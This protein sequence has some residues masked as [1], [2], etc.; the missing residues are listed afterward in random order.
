MNFRL[1]SRFCGQV[2][3]LIA[4]ILLVQALWCFY[5][6]ASPDLGLKLIAS[7]VVILASGIILWIVGHKHQG[8]IKPREA[9][10]IVA[11]AWFLMSIVG[12]LPYLLAETSLHFADAFFE[13]VSGFTT[14]GST[15]LKDIEA[16][17]DAVL[18]WRSF[19]QWI[20]GLGVIVLFVSI[21]PSLGVAGGK[22]LFKMEMPGPIKENITPKIR[23]TTRYLLYAYLMLTVVEAL[24]LVFVS[25]MPWFD[26]ITHS[27]STISTGGFS[28][29]NASI[30]SYHSAS[31]EWII[32]VFMFL[33]GTNFGLYYL[34]IHGQIKVALKDSE[35]RFYAVLIVLLSSIITISLTFYNGH[36]IDDSVRRNLSHQI[37]DQHLE[38]LSLLKQEQ[39]TTTF[40]LMQELERV[41]ITEPQVQKMIIVNSQKNYEWQIAIRKS[42]FQVVALI[43]TTGF[44]SDD[45]ELYPVFVHMFLFYLLFCGGCAGSTA[46]GVKLFRILLIGKTFL[47]EIKTGFRPALVSKIRVGSTIISNDLIRTVLAFVGIY[48]ACIA[49]GALYLGLEGHSLIT[50]LT[51][52]MTAVG[53]F[54]PGFGEIG[55]TE[56][57]SHFSSDAKIMLGIL[58]LLGRLE[59]FTLLTFLHYRFWK[60]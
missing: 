26:A 27:F 51:A 15:I 21:F 10:M 3:L 6:D 18:F 49:I 7:M 23:D 29:K 34:I 4:C 13:S 16:L 54:G 25:Q 60:R 50:A 32:I 56:N 19:T 24:L 20:G 53:N 58:M 43:T 59:F 48:F 45:Y 11:Y 52:S 39:F 40:F 31:A 12:T 1:I 9:L 22:S 8:D 47:H 2:N 37:E 38:K 44:A 55:P 14:T 28:I 35:L 33:G 46:G 30:G 41:E 17:P 5:F 36:E 42:I 57:F